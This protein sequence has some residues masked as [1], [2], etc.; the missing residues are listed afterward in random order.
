MDGASR[1]LV[2]AQAELVR[3]A[4]VADD[5]EVLLGQALQGE[6][7]LGNENALLAGGK[8]LDELLA[9]RVVDHAEAAVGGRVIGGVLE[10]V[11]LAALQPFLSDDLRGDGD[12]AGALEGQDLGEA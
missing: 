3:T 10:L 2:D 12:E 8:P 6:V 7:N 5:V 1:V 9:P 11:N 4:V